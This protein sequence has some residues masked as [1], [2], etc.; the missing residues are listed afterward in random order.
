M[1]RAPDQLSRHD[2]AMLIVIAFLFAATIAAV[3]GLS[4]CAPPGGGG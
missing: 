4:Q 1:T 3:I 2:W